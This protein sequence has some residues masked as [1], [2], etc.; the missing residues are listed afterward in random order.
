MLM[1]VVR[2][3]RQKGFREKSRFIIFFKKKA[4]IN[5]VDGR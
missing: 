3:E 1:L 2:L 4:S 5:A